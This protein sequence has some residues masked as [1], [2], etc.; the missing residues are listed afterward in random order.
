LLD[1]HE[2]GLRVDLALLEHVEVL[3]VLEVNELLER[4]LEGALLLAVKAARLEIVD[5]HQDA[6]QVRDLAELLGARLLGLALQL[7]LLVLDHLE[8][9]LQ[10]RDVVVKLH[11]LGF[12][13]FFVLCYLVFEVVQLLLEALHCLLQLDVRTVQGFVTG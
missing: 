10:A 8:L 4:I 12:H 3:G 11:N 7:V 6:G 9:L 1:K 2:L 5:G 13:V